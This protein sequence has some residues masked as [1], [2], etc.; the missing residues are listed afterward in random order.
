[1]IFN[2][3]KRAPLQI[4]QE[5]FYYITVIIHLWGHSANVSP[6][7]QEAFNLDIIVS[8]LYS[9]ESTVPCRVNKILARAINR[10]CCKPQVMENWEY[11]PCFRLLPITHLHR[12]AFW[13]NFLI[14]LINP[15]FGRHKCVSR[16]NITLL[17]VLLD[18]VFWEK[19][20]WSI[21]QK[22]TRN[23]ELRP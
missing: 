11:F 9:K 10:F 12:S 15:T 8:V 17:S 1:M 20:H 21:R 16:D 5:I 7:R 2:V 6:W 13:S 18:F 3:L 19:F 4:N 22:H 14:A 23:T